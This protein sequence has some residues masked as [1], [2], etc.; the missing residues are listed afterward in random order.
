MVDYRQAIT[1]V[2]SMFR[3]D[4]TLPARRRFAE[5]QAVTLNFRLAV[6]VT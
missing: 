5:I 3:G 4:A 2:R 1:R 6:M